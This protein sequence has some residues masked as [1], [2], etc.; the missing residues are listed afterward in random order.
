M[1]IE[2]YKENDKDNWD[3]FIRG[4]KNGT[5]LFIRD[6]M[7][8]HHDRF[9]DNSLLI[10]DK[11]NALVSVLPANRKDNI[12][13]SHGGLTF[14]GFIISEKMRMES[15][16][17]L[18]KDIIAYLQSIGVKEFIYKAIPYIYYSLPSDEDRYALFRFGADLYRRDVTVTLT[19][20]ATA[21]LQERR[22]RAIKK[23]RDMGVICL[24]SE[25]FSS[26]WKI[27]EENLSSVYGVLP[28]H[29]IDEITLL[30]KLFP[31][32]IKLFCSFIGN[33]MISGVVIYE[34]DNVAHV[35]YIA[36]SIKGRSCSGLDLLFS[37]LITDVYSNK[38]YF[39]FGISNENEGLIL[40]SGLIDFKEGFGGRAVV[41]DFYRL[42]L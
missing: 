20:S 15:M 32:N 17:L 26:F 39:D 34:S 29:N 10:Y 27:L 38:K 22:N 2:K 42:K 7:D 16:L 40:N 13:I 41:H 23:A 37:Y 3:H 21:P 28:V 9:C 12:L 31:E 25:D 8:Y 35:Q 18:F 6:Y 4:S 36:S 33:Q 19:P 5:F 24:S 1:C 11:K 30:H 14:G